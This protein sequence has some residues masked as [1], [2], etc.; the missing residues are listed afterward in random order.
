M[1]AI[2]RVGNKVHIDY[3]PVNGVDY[4]AMLC[5]EALNDPD[6]DSLEIWIDY[7]VGSL[8]SAYMGSMISMNILAGQLARSMTI[9]CGPTLQRWFSII[10][11]NQ[12][13]DIMER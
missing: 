4:F 2:R 7:S 9:H 1:S 10:G 5:I 8:S 13:L 11:G 12:I 6:C 3:E